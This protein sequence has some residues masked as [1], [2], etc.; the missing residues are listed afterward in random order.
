MVIGLVWGWKGVVW[1]GWGSGLGW[2]VHGMG[3]GVVWGGGS[4]VE[5]GVVVLYCSL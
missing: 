2:G 3:I 1:E 4:S 5:G